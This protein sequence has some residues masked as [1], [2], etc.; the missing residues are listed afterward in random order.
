MNK[1]L[2][3]SSIIKIEL[4]NKSHTSTFWSGIEYSN[5]I[6]IFG[7]EI[8]SA[9]LTIKD[10]TY[11]LNNPEDVKMLP[12]VMGNFTYEF[13]NKKISLF[14]KPHVRIYYDRTCER[15]HFETFE[16]CEKFIKDN[17]SKIER[18]KFIKL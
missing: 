6:K 13:K 9:H 10:K 18:A 4:V 12:K 16:E 17:F 5:G 2:R 14:E 15:V 3:K 11:F 7:Y 1:L 8:M